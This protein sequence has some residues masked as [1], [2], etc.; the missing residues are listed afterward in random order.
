MHFHISDG[1]I[2][3]QL[4]KQ[5]WSLEEKYLWEILELVI[6]RVVTRSWQ[7]EEKEEEEI[8]KNNTMKG[9]EQKGKKK[10]ANDGT[11]MICYN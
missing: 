5:I 7:R 6:V 4:D 11:H 1:A 2:N 3:K 9:G 8:H 10:R